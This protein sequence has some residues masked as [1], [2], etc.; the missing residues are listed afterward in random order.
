MQQFGGK[1]SKRHFTVVM[2]NKEHGLY[3]SSTPSSA[4]KKAVT[5]LC[6][7][8][9]GKKVEFHIREITQGSKKKTYG[10]YDGYIEKLK[11]PIELKGRVIKYKPVAKLSK[12][13]GV[14][15]GGMFKAFG[16]PAIVEVNPCYH[17][18]TKENRIR[19]TALRIEPSLEGNYVT[20]RGD[21]ILLNEKEI[22]KI[23][24][25]KKDP[26]S[27]VDFGRVEKDGVSGWVRMNYI[28]QDNSNGSS[29]QCIFN[30][31]L[32]EARKLWKESFEPAPRRS[33]LP[34]IHKSLL[35]NSPNINNSLLS[36]PK[37]EK[38]NIFGLNKF[39]PNYSAKGQP[40][41]LSRYQGQP[42]SLA[43][44]GRPAASFSGFP[45]QAANFSGL[46]RQAANYSR[47]PG[48]AA[49]LLSTNIQV[50]AKLYNSK[51][52]LE[53]LYSIG[54]HIIQDAF[55]PKGQVVEVL[56]TVT[57]FEN[58]YNKIR[59]K[60]SK[61]QVVEGFVESINLKKT[62]WLCDHRICLEFNGPY[63][64]DQNSNKNIPVSVAVI[65]RNA[66]GYILVGTETDKK[67]FSEFDRSERG[68]HLLAG[69]IDPR[70]CPVYSSYDETA[71]EGRFLPLKTLRRNFKLWDSFFKPDG[72]YR[73]TPWLSS[74]RAIV[75]VGEIE[76]DTDFIWDASN[77]PNGKPELFKD[78]KQL[79]NVFTELRQ[80]LK[81][82]NENHK[83][84][85]K[86]KFKWVKPLP[87]G[88]E[89]TD[90]DD[91]SRDNQMYSWGRNIIQDY[92]NHSIQSSQLQAASLSGFP[93]IAA[94]L[95]RVPRQ[96]ANISRNS[97]V[98]DDLL[99]RV[100]EVHEQYP[101]SSVQMVTNDK[102][103]IHINNNLRTIIE[104]TFIDDNHHNIGSQIYEST[105]TGPLVNTEADFDRYIYNLIESEMKSS[106]KNLKYLLDLCA[107][108]Y[109]NLL[110]TDIPS[111]KL[112][113]LRKYLLSY[114]IEKRGMQANG[115]NTFFHK[116]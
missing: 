62:R 71:E 16:G 99:K 12:K 81:D 3:V 7:A 56:E 22:V 48:P 11:E 82:N 92:V 115:S 30:P 17:Y 50:P 27:K 1:D 33:I 107:D 58:K 44:L 91:W 63:D 64:E 55:I 79:D 37:R 24:E 25:I 5:K 88:R 104:R 87:K 14:K 26:K 57:N 29:V 89:N 70:S 61:S 102:Y 15:K 8:N 32:G 60:T 95:S 49:S 53:L 34:N 100:R 38:P 67:K 41:S 2:G 112:N 78:P 9:K 74:G 46:G 66:K 72:K 108:T 21:P 69:K 6:A 111:K 4:A 84:L 76:K 54:G 90:W 109:K 98:E 73:M 13:I 101:G 110:K 80:Q 52:N 18:R 45:G 35:N 77:P 39:Q 86:I 43:G 96:A 36:I 103:I 19:T 106:Q 93:G 28:L 59:A 31:K 94:S 20:D 97:Q 83:Y 85:E 75:F 10:P 65:L 116:L 51:D 23:L 105:F 40:A 47:V 114:P 42:A 68:Y 113:D